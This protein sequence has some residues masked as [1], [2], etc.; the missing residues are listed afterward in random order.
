MPEAIVIP[1]RLFGPGSPLLMY[2]ASVAERRGADVH[3]HY[4]TGE[5]PPPF[6][7]P[8]EGWVRGELT[9]LLDRVGGRPLLIGKSLG[10]HAAALAAERDLPAI[11]LTPL[12][13]AAA[14]TIALARA[15]APFLL[16]GGTA[17]RV[18]DGELARRLTPHVFQVESADHGMYVPGPLTASVTVLGHVVEAVS[19]FLD[20]IGWPAT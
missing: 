6:E 2:A 14:V 12:L 15:T 20:E 8:V 1:G 16:V 4:W 3:H 11:W 18:W 10:T 17:D 19:E 9:P 13:T 7:P 5:P